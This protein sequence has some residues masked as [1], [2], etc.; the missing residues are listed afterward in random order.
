MCHKTASFP[1]SGSWSL[2]KAIE[3]SYAPGDNWTVTVE[4]EPGSIY[5][6]KYAVID[7]NTKQ[8]IAWQVGDDLRC[9]GSNLKGYFD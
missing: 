9:A 8:A 4:L 7:F 3:L 2:D 6:Y 1:F 5:E